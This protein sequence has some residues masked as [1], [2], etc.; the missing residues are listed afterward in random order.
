MGSFEVITD[1]RAAYP[2][3]FQTNVPLSSD[4]AS[5]FTEEVIDPTIVELTYM[6]KEISR[7]LATVPTLRVQRS[8][9]YYR[10][11]WLL[12]TPIRLP[13]FPAG[14]PGE[15]FILGGPCLDEHPMHQTGSLGS[16]SVVF[17]QPDL[18][19]RI[20]I[21]EKDRGK[22]ANCVYL[23]KCAIAHSGAMPLQLRLEMPNTMW[24]YSEAYQS[25]L[26]ELTMVS[27]RWQCLSIHCPKEVLESLHVVHG[28]FGQ[29]ERLVLRVGT[30]DQALSEDWD[31][32]QIR[33]FHIAPRLTYVTLQQTQ[34]M[35]R[36]P[37]S[38]LT[39]IRHYLATRSLLGIVPIQVDYLDRCTGLTELHLVS[40]QKQ[41]FSFPAVICL[42][43][44]CS[45]HISD[46]HIV[47]YLNAPRLK[48]LYCETPYDD[49]YRSYHDPIYFECNDV[50]PDIH[51]FLSG[52]QGSLEILSILDFKE[53]SCRL[54]F[55]ILHCTSLQFLSALELRY[56][57]WTSHGYVAFD[58]GLRRII[59]HLIVRHSQIPVL[60]HL[61]TFSV[62]I[63]NI[64]HDA[65][66]LS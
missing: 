8:R 28:R 56:L 52:I 43:S 14:G 45:L 20:S 17:S 54:L 48:A 61:Q 6:D 65:E 41:C 35:I 62:L 55:G 38:Q 47:N 12:D 15:D 23:L 50:L 51:R 46:P 29:L 64:S 16:R 36:L 19:T 40:N 11:Q 53:E 10:Y 60:T 27:E 5:K 25:W 44:L 31:A 37:I 7:L 3:Y 1:F 58:E 4:D 9:L 42:E 66:S 22:R 33:V 26:Q 59:S 39:D 30:E 32:Y 18:W 63:N 2:Q 34:S 24:A 49:M 13:C 21:E 57:Q